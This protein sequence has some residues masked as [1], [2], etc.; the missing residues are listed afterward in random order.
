MNMKRDIEKRLGM[1]GAHPSIPHG[2]LLTSLVKK[3]GEL[4]V[5]LAVADRLRS[6]VFDR[7]LD[8][9][10]PTMT[11]DEWIELTQSKRHPVLRPI[12][13]LVDGKLV[14]VT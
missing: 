11:S 1:H 7:M 8:L 12:A 4:E 14:D 10:R 6:S 13:K 9:V 5:E 2:A 3:Y